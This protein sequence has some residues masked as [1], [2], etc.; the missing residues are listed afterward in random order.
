VGPSA[1]KHLLFSAELIDAERA[2]RIGLIDE[3]A[4]PAAAIGRLETFTS[5]LANERSLLT[6]TISKEMVNEVAAHGAVS[7]ATIE[8]WAHVLANNPDMPEGV[9][10]FAERRSPNFVWVP[11][12]SF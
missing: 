2:L 5:L 1:A 8:R 3:L 10:A 6:Q 4:E 11:E 12:E 7:G 9:A